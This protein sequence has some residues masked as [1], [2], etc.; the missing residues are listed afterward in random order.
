MYLIKTVFY[1]S[2]QNCFLFHVKYSLS[3]NPVVPKLGVNYPSGEGAVTRNQNQCCS[4]LWAITAKYWG[5][6]RHNHY[7]D[8]GNGSNRFRKHW[9]NRMLFQ[10]AVGISQKPNMHSLKPSVLCRL[11][12]CGKGHWHDHRP[13]RRRSANRNAPRRRRRG[14][15]KLVEGLPGLRKLH[16]QSGRLP[17]QVAGRRNAK[18][19]CGRNGK[20]WPM[21]VNVRGGWGGGYDSRTAEAT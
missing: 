18:Q 9:L 16:R 8:L 4:V 10:P 21:S 14:R 6:L 19:L 15:D 5:Q 12:I 20:L 13:S 17:Q 2:K 1:P 7:L 11:Q 3:L